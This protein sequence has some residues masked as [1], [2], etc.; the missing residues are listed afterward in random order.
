MTK[1]MRQPSLARCRRS[2]LPAIVGLLAVGAATGC[3]GIDSSQKL[4]AV[5]VSVRDFRVKS[6]REL[7]S[8]EVRLRVYN[9]GPD[10][11]ELILVRTGQ[12][13]LPLRAD[14][15]TVDEDA[16]ES[17]TVTTVDG[18][19]PGVRKEARIHLRPGRYV[20][21]CNMAGHYL[22]GMHTIVVA[23]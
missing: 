14:G 1:V 19:E 9:K 23:R 15:L 7:P 18:L 5:N 6:E 8:G 11:H 3:A 10:T 4:P 13:P 17:L 20:L 22:S 21:F 16:L 12:G 2:L